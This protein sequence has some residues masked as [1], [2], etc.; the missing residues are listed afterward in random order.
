MALTRDQLEALVNAPQESLGVELK[1]WI[2]PGTAE[3]EAKVAKGVL[4]L[5]NHGGGVFV[6][7]FT[8][9]GEPDTGAGPAD[10]CAAFHT[11]MVQALVGKYASTPFEV[12]VHFVERD[13]QTFPVIEVPPGVTTPVACKRDFPP[14]GKHLLKDNAVYVRSLHSNG[15][16]SSSEAK[17]DDWERLMK[18]CFDNREADIGG[19]VR[20]H[21]TGIDLAGLSALL[22]RTR[23]PDPPTASGRA[24]DLMERGRAR[25]HA[26]CRERSVS[27]P[28]IGFREAAIIVAG[29]VP[30]HS[31]TQDFLHRLTVAKPRY[32]GWSPWP[33]GFQSDPAR[34][35]Q[36]VYENGWEALLK[37][38]DS[39]DFWRIDPRGEFY[40]LDALREDLFGDPSMPAGS[41]LD[42]V[43]Q[44]RRLVEY[45][46]SAQSF[47]RSMGCSEGSTTLACRFRWRGLQGRRLVNRFDP[48]SLYPR[49]P[50]VQD[51][52]TSAVDVPLEVATAALGVLVFQAVNPLFLV[53]GGV[54][55]AER[56]IARRV[57]EILE[58]RMG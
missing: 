29:H 5:R 34:D 39:L 57:E 16:V 41:S 18:V 21:L 42:F 28:A 45:I 22:G 7:G 24:A 38:A 8:D 37:L 20:R 43:T 50:A 3:G 12:T 1:Q 13:G 9:A 44:I 40:Q 35:T 54:E 55:V 31:P 52:V 46:T 10:V 58:Q 6:V 25:F 53:F 32:S 15:T 36:Y 56:V 48:S 14:G 51:E 33:A 11:D 30:A 23:P 27:L 47:A 19:F 4:A 2:D 17:R 26:V 49:P